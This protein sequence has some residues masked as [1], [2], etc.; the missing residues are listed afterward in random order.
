MIIFYVSRHITF[1]FQKKAIAFLQLLILLNSPVFAGNTIV[2]NS[3]VDGMPIIRS[4]FVEAPGIT[5][6]GYVG[7]KITLT[8]T[9]F[10]DITAVTINKIPIPNLNNIFVDQNT[11]I[12]NAIDETGFIEIRTRYNGGA[13]YATKYTSLGYITSDAGNWN[14]DLT[15]LNKNIPPNTENTAIT[16]A[17][18][19][20]AASGILSV[21][22]LTINESGELTISTV[23]N[24]FG[25]CVNKGALS[26]EGIFRLQGK[27]SFSGKPPI[28]SNSSALEYVGYKGDAKDEWNGN[29]NGKGMG[30]GTGIPFSVILRNT[31]NLRISNKKLSLGSGIKIGDNCSFILNSSSITI[32]GDWEKSDSATFTSNAASITFRGS[33]K[34]KVIGSNAFTNVTISNS[35]GIAFLGATS[36][37]EMLNFIV[38]KVFLEKENFTMMTKAIVTGY[39]NRR[40]IV[41]QSSGKLL[42]DALTEGTVYP[43]GNKAYNP[44][45]LKTIFSVNYGVR[46]TDSLPYNLNKDKMINRAWVISGVSGKT[47]IKEVTAQY[48][49]GEAGKNFDKTIPVMG[50]LNN[51][52]ETNKAVLT[53]VVTSTTISVKNLA[54]A[55]D[56]EYLIIG[57][58]IETKKESAPIVATAEKEVQTYPEKEIQYNVT[59]KPNPFV[60]STKI[61]ITLPETA[62]TV[63]VFD[64]GGKLVQEEKREG[65][66]THTIAIGDDFPSGVYT[67]IVTTL[68]KTKSI[69]IVKR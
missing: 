15:W 36:I 34:Q 26:N 37:S 58:P 56:E 51:G 60:T 8:G 38:G 24:L 41:T 35:N 30:A 32:G 66:N 57:N 6:A 50:F 25:D 22:S 54:K 44:I 29:G 4:V 31:A 5:M 67:A 40:Y 12:F 59:V 9:N 10:V 46:V 39:N 13:I 69:R 49:R 61:V 19:V 52:W 2:K 1:F 33:D 27:S 28:Y 55:A 62:V 64:A 14:N 3:A 11:I 43:V 17:H 65:S 16:I 63:K 23:F 42:Q 47:M 68:S 21:G 45:T 18:A 48:N 7:C 20:K 53:D